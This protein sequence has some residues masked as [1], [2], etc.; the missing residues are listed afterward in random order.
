M[1]DGKPV[2]LYIDDDQDFLDGMR[3]ILE[4]NGYLM[5]EAL[6]AEDGL[7]VFR[8]EEPDLGRTESRSK[9]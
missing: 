4:A 2:I 1:Q 9:P 3:V 5:V 7:K 8:D 6:T